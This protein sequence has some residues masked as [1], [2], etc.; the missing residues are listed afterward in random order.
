[1]LSWSPLSHFAVAQ[2][3]GAQT[4]TV[5]ASWLSKSTCPF[6]QPWQSRNNSVPAA[7]NGV[8]AMRGLRQS[9]AAGTVWEVASS[10]VQVLQLHVLM[11]WAHDQG[12]RDKCVMTCWWLVF[13][14][15]QGW[16]I[17]LLVRLLLRR[18]SASWKVL[19]L[20][21]EWMNTKLYRRARFSENCKYSKITFSSFWDYC[22]KSYT[23]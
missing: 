8:F 11:W 20:R 1:M 6:L 17:A 5:S 9:A 16:V 3:G 21:A 10:G 12:W 23:L 19:A 18:A 13:M 2:A 14:E 7:Q 4:N 15:V 22:S